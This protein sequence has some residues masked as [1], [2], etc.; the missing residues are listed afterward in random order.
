MSKIVK[1]VMIGYDGGGM[2]CGPVSGS[3]VGEMTIDHD[4]RILYVSGSNMGEAAVYFVT[5]HSIYDILMDGE[6]SFSIVAEKE[7]AIFFGETGPADL[8]CGEEEMAESEYYN[9]IKYLRTVLWDNDDIDPLE[10]T[11][12]YGEDVDL[13]EDLPTLASYND[14]DDD[15]YDYEDD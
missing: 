4:G 13:M 2:A 9:C 7:K 14:Y 3:Y 5:D 10:V 8:F 6:E 11:E 12:A 1:K 15:D